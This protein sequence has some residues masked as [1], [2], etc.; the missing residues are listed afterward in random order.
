ILGLDPVL[1][2]EAKNSTR[3]SGTGSRCRCSPQ[4]QPRRRDPTRTERTSRP[5]SPRVSW[6]PRQRV[7]QTGLSGSSVRL[8]E[9][10]QVVV[11]IHQRELS[12]TPKLQLRGRSL[13]GP[14]ICGATL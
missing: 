1:E 7:Y 8:A 12:E 3:S 11:R 13:R 2:P 10:E 5:Y 9:P 14:S 4:E 6:R